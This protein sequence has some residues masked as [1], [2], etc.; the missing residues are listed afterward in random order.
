VVVC[1][2]NIKK[3]YGEKVLFENFSISIQEGEFVCITGKSGT[4]K[5]TLLNIIGLLEKPDSGE[6]SL[7]QHNNLVPNS[8]MAR[9]LLKEKIGFLFQ[10]YAL[11]EER[12]VGYNLDIASIHTKMGKKEWLCRKQEVLNQLDLN[13]SLKEKIYKLSGGEQQRVALARVLLKDCELILAD[14]PTGSLDI[15]NRDIILEI[16]QKLNQE[17]RTIIIASHDPYVVHASQR[18]INLD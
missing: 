1:L 12:T 3:A 17:N 18:I 2:K 13:V 9:T 5:S 15:E 10:N 8:N 16:L 7:F 4:G 11:V 14:E 6:V